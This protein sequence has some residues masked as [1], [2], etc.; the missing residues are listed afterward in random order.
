MMTKKQELRALRKSI[1]L[2]MADCA[3]LTGTPYKTWQCWEMEGEAGRR[4][5]G[6]PF[7]WLKLYAE[8]MSKRMEKMGMQGWYP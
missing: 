2:S 3:R 6:L 8:N 7:A 1:G 4:V 5:P